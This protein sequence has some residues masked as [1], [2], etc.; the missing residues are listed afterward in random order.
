[1]YG[2]DIAI[3]PAFR[4]LSS[5]VD[6]PIPSTVSPTPCKMLLI[7]VRFTSRRICCKTNLV[8]SLIH[9]NKISS[10]DGM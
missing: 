8:R 4:A 5:L 9:V 3:R 2:V 10:N 7:S 1:M 6:F